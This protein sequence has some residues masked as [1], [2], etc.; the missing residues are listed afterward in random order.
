[1]K[2]RYPGIKPFDI[3]YQNL[4]FGRDKDI[5]RLYRRINIEKLVVLYSKSGLGKS[6]LL[7]AGIIPKLKSEDNYK[8]ISIRF[9]SFRKKEIFSPLETLINSISKIRKDDTFIDQIYNDRLHIHCLQD[10]VH[11]VIMGCFKIF[12]KIYF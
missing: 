5:N 6:S 2:N 4:F 7:N 11:D 9:F 8:P 1:M 10:P 12:K 3:E